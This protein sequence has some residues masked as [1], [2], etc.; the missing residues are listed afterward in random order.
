M[1]VSDDPYRQNRA[2]QCSGLAGARQEMD[3][4]IELAKPSFFRVK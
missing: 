3:G 1:H 4:D 2:K